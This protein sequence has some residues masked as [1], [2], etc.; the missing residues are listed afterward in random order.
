M[1]RTFCRP[2]ALLLGG[3]FLAVIVGARPGPLLAQIPA[4]A[5]TAITVPTGTT[6]RLQMSTK[7]AIKLVKNSRENVLGIKTIPG[8]PTGIDLT[9]QDGGVTHLELTDADGKVETFSIIVQADVEYLH[10]S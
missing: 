1:H 9:G 8:D 10:S 5:S 4:S 2:H 3:L 6:T 7:K